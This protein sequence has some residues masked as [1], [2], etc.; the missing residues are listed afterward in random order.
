[1][2]IL[3]TRNITYEMY[4]MNNRCT[5]LTEKLIQITEILTQS[6]GNSLFGSLIIIC[7][8]KMTAK[9]LR[10]QLLNSIALGQ[11]E[12]AEEAKQ[13]PNV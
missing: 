8:L 6:A 2:D 10:R 11:Y 12:Y 3:I 9:E 1:M 13:N 7:I 5:E 4:K